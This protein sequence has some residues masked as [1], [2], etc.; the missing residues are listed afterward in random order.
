MFGCVVTAVT[1]DQATLE[2]APD[3]FD[4]EL[5]FDSDLP[6]LSDEPLDDADPDFESDSALAPDSDFEPS[7]LSP[8]LPFEEP[9]L[10]APARLSVR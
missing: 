1:V 4:P 8:D 9:P 10:T 2:S 5:D 6:E 3:F 7:E